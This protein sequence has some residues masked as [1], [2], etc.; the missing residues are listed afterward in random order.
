[1]VEFCSVTSTELHFDEHLIAHTMG[2][3]RTIVNNADMHVVCCIICIGALFYI[4]CFIIA[5]V[6]ILIERFFVESTSTSYT[7]KACVASEC[8]TSSSSTST[9]C[10]SFVASAS[11]VSKFMLPKRRF[12]KTEQKIGRAFSMQLS[13]PRSPNRV[14]THLKVLRKRTPDLL[15]C[16]PKSSFGE[17]KVSNAFSANTRRVVQVVD[18]KGGKVA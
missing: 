12:W 8:S 6:R 1:M 4:G 18:F 2:H 16:L 5:I 10:T 3:I 15:F 9:S 11:G 17:H 14:L 13:M 7:Y